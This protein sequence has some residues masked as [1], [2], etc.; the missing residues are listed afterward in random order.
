VAAPNPQRSRV[1][2]HVTLSFDIPRNLPDSVF[3]AL[4]TPLGVPIHRVG[5]FYDTKVGKGCG[6]TCIWNGAGYYM[7][8]FTCGTTYPSGKTFYCSA[9]CH[10]PR[11]HSKRVFLSYCWEDSAVADRITA[12]CLGAG[13]D[14]LRDLARVRVR[15]SISEFMALAAD[16][17]YF[18]AVISP[19]Y[20][21]SRYCV[22]ELAT[23][24]ESPAEIRVIPV[25]LES[26]AS[27][28]MEAKY[29]AHWDAAFSELSRSVTAIPQQY[30]RYLDAEVRLTRDAPRYIADCLTEVRTSGFVDAAR[31][32]EGN[33]RQLVGAIVATY[34]PTD[35]DA[36]NWT[37]SN[38]RVRGAKGKL[39]NTP[40]WKPTRC[41]VHLSG[42][43]ADA[44]MR[45]QSWAQR[46][47]RGW[48][49]PD[50]DA[51]PLDGKHL[52]VLNAD[53][54]T[55]L[56]L[57]QRLVRLAD[58]RRANVIPVFLDDEFTRPTSELMII[59]HWQRRMGAAS[60]SSA[61]RDAI[62]RVLCRL[63]SVIQMLRD[64]RAPDFPA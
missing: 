51:F 2:T 20:C 19:R 35:E 18:I 8:M 48:H 33:C 62:H 28:D 7:D 45:N 14:V 36:T 40:P 41:H 17:R 24:I 42:E 60:T 46:H 3:Y 23:V 43:R 44:V 61:E 15:D 13:V 5:N 26:A 16:S 53:F 58:S 21:F 39:V 32:L 55:Q 63:G 6:R 50:D 57:C 22:F 11:G 56:T 27:V 52:V 38:P 1:A 49:G 59:E 4:N 64:C 30:V 37:F 10:D 34:A 31:W 29:V 25:V 9:D 54:L 12:A 47:V